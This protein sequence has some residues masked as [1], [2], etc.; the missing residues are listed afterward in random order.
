MAKE[1]NSKEKVCVLLDLGGVVIETAG[2]SILSEK[3]SNQKIQENIREVWEAENSNIEF[4]CGNIG[5]EEYAERFLEKW[6][7][8]IPVDEFKDIFESFVVG[9]YCDAPQILEKIR[10]RHN[11]ACLSN[12][13]DV[14]WNKLLCQ[15]GLTEKF[16]Y[17]FAS[18]IL[19][20]R[21]P[22]PQAY[23]SVIGELN[24][25]PNHF[26][27]FDDRE[28]NVDAAIKCGMNASL[29]KGCGELLH[30]LL[31]YGLID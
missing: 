25:S 20:V 8:N 18:H 31:Q 26:Y 11:L 10:Q 5:F 17:C 7:Q 28:E 9:W 6:D 14:H 24:L 13:N 22:D 12:T 30:S 15:F 19:R 2:L 29:V 27:F 16:D 4:E 23:T 1:K 3:L 21:K